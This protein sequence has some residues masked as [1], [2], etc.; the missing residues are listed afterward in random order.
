MQRSTRIVVKLS[1]VLVRKAVRV[2]YPSNIHRLRGMII[3]STAAMPDWYLQFVDIDCFTVQY[4]VRTVS[5]YVFVH[6]ELPIAQLGGT[7]AA[8]LLC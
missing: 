5:C 7:G 8:V 3:R 1:V 4:R 6:Y 2:Y